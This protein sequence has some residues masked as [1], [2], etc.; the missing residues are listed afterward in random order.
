MPR[1]VKKTVILPDDLIKEVEE[2]ARAEGKSFSAILREA[3]FLFREE[4]MKDEFRTIQA[5]WV[6][7][8]RENGILTEE[9]LER[10]LTENEGSV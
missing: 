9:D 6:R 3:L 4:R 10:Y 1:G 7:K 5:Y 8:A 2:V